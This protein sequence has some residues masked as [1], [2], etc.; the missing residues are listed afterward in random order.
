MNHARFEPARA[1][2]QPVALELAGIFRSYG[3]DY[4]L[5]YADQLLPSHRQVMHAIL[6]VSIHN[7]RPGIAGPDIFIKLGVY[8]N[9]N[10]LTDRCAKNCSNLMPAI[11]R[12]IRPTPRKT[13]S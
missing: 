6:I 1:G 8:R 12:Q 9:V 10:I 11:G 4:R 5:K 7:F 2:S 13:D 3:P